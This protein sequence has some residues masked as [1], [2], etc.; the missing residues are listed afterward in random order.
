MKGHNPSIHMTPLKL[1]L[2]IATMPHQVQQ[3]C[4]KQIHYL[5][6]KE[7]ANK[8]NQNKPNKQNYNKNSTKKYWN[9]ASFV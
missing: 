8:Q 9:N 4:K 1:I 6:L 7:K 3:N 5:T 2:L